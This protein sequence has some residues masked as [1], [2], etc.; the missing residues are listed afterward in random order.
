MKY[1]SLPSGSKGWRILS[2]YYFYFYLIF[3]LEKGSF[4]PTVKLLPY[5]LEITGSSHGNSLL[6]YKIRLRTVDLSLGSYIG[7]RFMHRIDF[8]IYF[9]HGLNFPSMT[10]YSAI[11]LCTLSWFSTFNPRSE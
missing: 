2:V 8:F 9:A 6:L 7:W 5:N 11:S 3:L 1:A 4:S 10:T